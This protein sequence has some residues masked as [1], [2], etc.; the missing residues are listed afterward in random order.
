MA[1]ALH[2]FIYTSPNKGIDSRRYF[3]TKKDAI[4]YV[5]HH[6]LYPTVIFK[7][8]KDQMGFMSIE[9]VDPEYGVLRR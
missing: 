5:K 9:K 6:P 7:V 4:H 2:Y 1:K 8:Y 3:K